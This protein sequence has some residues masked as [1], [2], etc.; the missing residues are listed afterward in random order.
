MR[1]LLA[2]MAF[3]LLTCGIEVAAQRED[4]ST[5]GQGLRWFQVEVVVFRQPLSSS[6]QENLLHTDPLPLPFDMI[7]LLPRKGVPIRPRLMAHLES[8]WLTNAFAPRLRV[9]RALTREF[10]NPIQRAELGNVRAGDYGTSAMLREG[11]SGAVD[12]MPASDDPTRAPAASRE[13]I[14]IPAPPQALMTQEELEAALAVMPEIPIEAAYTELPQEEHVL[15]REA[16]AL[17]RRAG[18]RV[19]A[20]HA[21]LQPLEE[22]APPTPVLIAAR[23]D[24]RTDAGGLLGTVRVRLS[25]FLHAQIT[26]SFPYGGAGGGYAHLVEARRMRSQKLHYIDHPLFGALIRIDPYPR[27]APEVE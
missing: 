16:S 14:D 17:A 19:L 5:H 27:P 20:H 3:G 8:G 4:Q 15:G 24:E 1:V 10:Q 23:D 2:S 11:T 26:F 13:P 6:L 9:L 18:Y 7:A 22:N 12:G 21:W 25:R